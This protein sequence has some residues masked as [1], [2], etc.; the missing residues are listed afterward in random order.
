MFPIAWIILKQIHPKKVA[1]YQLYTVTVTSGAHLRHLTGIKLQQIFIRKWKWYNY[2]PWKPTGHP[3]ILD[4]WPT[5]LQHHERLFKTS[6]GAAL[7]NEKE[8]GVWNTALHW[9]QLSLCDK[10]P[11]S[12]A[13]HVLRG[14][15]YLCEYKSIW[16]W[17][18]PLGQ[19]KGTGWRPRQ[20]AQR[21]REWSIADVFWNLVMG[22]RLLGNK[23]SETFRLKEKIEKDWITAVRLGL[24]QTHWLLFTAFLWKILKEE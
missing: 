11:P 2:Q 18:Y 7:L 9:Y 12:L 1:W 8:F 10:V 5:L 19:E 24:R 3:A 6:S 22:G 23:N 17:S 20:W 16:S 15:N 14:S 4:F 21:Q 13:S